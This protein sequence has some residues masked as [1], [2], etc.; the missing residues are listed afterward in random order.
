MGCI[1][2][3]GQFA[4][5]GSSPRPGGVWCATYPVFAVPET[6]TLSLA[7]QDKGWERRIV[8]RPQV[9]MHPHQE[10]GRPHLAHPL[11]LDR[12]IRTAGRF[13]LWIWRS[14][15][16]RAGQQPRRRGSPFP[17]A[18]ALF[19]LLILHPLQVC[20][21]TRGWRMGDPPS[22]HPSRKI[23]PAEYRRVLP[24]NTTPSDQFGGTPTCASR[25]SRP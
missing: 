18:I 13:S 25:D 11:S 15:E 6:G 17:N 14:K 5:R 20:Y 2:R 16:S 21:N 7:G 12:Q 22:L 10:T 24:P 23:D 8:C 4:L 3:W 9:Q 1:R 19:T